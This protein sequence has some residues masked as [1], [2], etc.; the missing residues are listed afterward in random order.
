MGSKSNDKSSDKSSD[1]A[2]DASV[3]ASGRDRL[4]FEPTRNRKKV[5]KKPAPPAP[6]RSSSPSTSRPRPASSS[7]A[8]PEVVSRRMIRR[9]ALFCGVPTALGVSTFFASYLIVTNELFKL[10]PTAVL[11]VSLGFF[12][13]GV[14]GLSYGVLSASWDEE[15]PGSPLGWAEFRLNFGRMTEA[16]RSSKRSS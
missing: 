4:P 12:G 10:P 7:M 14:L 13:L 2:N 3:N 5:E 9:M 6:S 15:S 16:W 8:I 11:L 1:K